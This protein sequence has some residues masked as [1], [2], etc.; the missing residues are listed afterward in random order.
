MNQEI[1]DFKK[2]QIE[3]NKVQLTEYHNG[4]LHNK[5]STSDQNS[6]EDSSMKGEFKEFLKTSY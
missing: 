3:L 5:R 1:E 2:T 6:T 4:F